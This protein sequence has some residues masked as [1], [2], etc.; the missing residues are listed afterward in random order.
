MKYLII[1]SNEQELDECLYDIADFFWNNGNQ[2][3][4]SN[5]YDN[6]FDYQCFVELCD[7]VVLL[8]YQDFSTITFFENEQEKFQKYF[9]LEESISK[10]MMLV[11]SLDGV[12]SNAIAFPYK[13]FHFDTLDQNE[14]KRFFRWCRKLNLFYK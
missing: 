13:I 10:K 7:W 2:V 3:F 4:I 9:N 8:I 5:N 14:L 1:E 12:Y 6:K 11:F